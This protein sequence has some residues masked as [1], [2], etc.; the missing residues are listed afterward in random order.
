MPTG[1]ALLAATLTVCSPLL[2]YS[3]LVMTEVLFYP[4]ST[5]ALLAVARAVKTAARRDQAIAL[6]LIAAAVATRVQAVVFFGVFGGAVLVDA[7][8]ARSTS[9]L[10]SFWPV[11]LVLVAASVAAAA[12]PGLFGA[13]SGTLHGG[14]PVTLSLRLTY[15][16]LAYAALMVA[17]VP[18]AAAGLLLVDA[19]RGRSHDAGERALLSVTVCAVVL[20]TTEVG[21]FAARYAPHL[22]G[23]NLAPLPPLFFVLFA[24][25]LARGAVRRRAVAA[26]TALLVLALI[27]FAPWNGLIVD[28]A[29]PD[30]FSVPL[31]HWAPADTVA[32]IAAAVL[33]LFVMLPRRLS[34]VLPALVVALLVASSVLASNLITDRASADQPMLV[35]TPRDWVDR[36]AHEPVA[37]LFSGDAWNVVWQQRFWNHRIDEV[38]SLSPSLV[39]GPMAQTRI[40]VPPTGRLPVRARL[41]VTTGDVTLVGSTVAHQSLGPD[42]S[43]LTLWRLDG[44]ATL[45]TI[46]YG[47]K[48]NGDMLGEG[49]L[50]AYDCRGGQ[51]QLT[52]LPKSTDLLEIDLNGRRVL[53]RQI[54][55]APSWHGTIAVPVAQQS[56]ICQFRIIGGALLGST[57]LDFTRPNN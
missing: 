14:Y 23:R 56:Q 20:I 16:H 36:A 21:V 6:L 12:A 11:W 41:V 18:V 40:V 55:G 33:L 10:R 7:L 39:P 15:D 2:L 9:R 4:L 53:R 54:A 46:T 3:G 19:V 50:T 30:S 25:W 45:S 49:D 52:L 57:V 38:G 27:V 26:V 31:V 37:Y 5:L 1:Y 44:P 24:L 22:L 28:D 8:L 48:P 43:G 35:G 51:L 17:V 42:S 13:Y 32:V 29:V 34:L 47:V